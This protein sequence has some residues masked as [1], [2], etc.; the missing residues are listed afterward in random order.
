MTTV[1]W[2]AKTRKAKVKNVYRNESRES[3]RHGAKNDI[4]RLLP[5]KEKNELLNNTFKEIE[6]IYELGNG[7]ET[8]SLT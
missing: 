7:T 3:K 2:K 1:F 4:C 8:L 6:V 5:A